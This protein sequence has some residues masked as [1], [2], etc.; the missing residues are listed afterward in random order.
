MKV[1]GKIAKMVLSFVMKKPATIGYPFVKP[2]IPKSFRGRIKFHPEKCIGCQ[3]CVRDC[4]ADAI[5][6][7]KIGDKKFECE[8][9]LGNCIYCGQCVDSC[10]KKAL[11]LTT[12]FELAQLDPKK[13][14][15]ILNEE[16]PQAPQE[17]PE[18][19]T[20]T[21]PEAAA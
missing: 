11:E 10:P 18:E 7:R 21:K 6:I 15:R 3:M 17:K 5:K 13:L 2:E 16:S 4:P 1:F 9:K 20:D 8:L 12:D 19:K 14:V